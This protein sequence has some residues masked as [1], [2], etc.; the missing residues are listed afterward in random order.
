MGKASSSKKVQRAAKAAGRPGA[1]K[2]YAWPITI[3]L[4]VLLGVVLIVVTV[5]APNDAEAGAPSWQNND[6]WHAAYGIFD[7]DSYVSPLQDIRQDDPLGIHT[8]GDG[9]MHIHPFAE[10]SS[11][12]GANLFHFGQ[13][14]GMTVSDSS[15]K[16]PTLNRK[17]GDKC[18][19]QVGHVELL[20]W[21]S[22][23]DKT[24][25]VIR[26]HIA[27]FAPKNQSAW[28]LAFVADGQDVPIPPSISGLSDPTAAEEGRAPSGQTV[29]STPS[30]ES[31][32]TTQGAPTSST[33][34]PA[35][36]AT[37]AAP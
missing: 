12:K 17:N 21:S 25:T 11:G 3:G 23:A 5:A 14:V 1:K 16:T 8:H 37:T 35:T 15:L 9:L 20:V 19:K 22:P 33:A 24:P 34:P 36:T 7:C 6:H 27:D 29:P 30:T 13:Q 18:G 10:Q 4:V 31:T 26:K 2:S 28:T 32:P